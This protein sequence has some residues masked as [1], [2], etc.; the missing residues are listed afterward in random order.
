MGDEGKS[1]VSVEL[2]DGSESESFSDLVGKPSP[3]SQPLSGE[4]ERERRVRFVARLP[5]KGT[6]WKGSLQ[7]VRAG[8]SC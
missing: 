5:C 8:R 1:R 6:G 3:G 4:E 2:S 7:G